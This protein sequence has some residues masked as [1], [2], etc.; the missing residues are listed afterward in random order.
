MP[1]LMIIQASVS[2][3]DKYKAYQEG[4]KP[5]IESFGGHFKASG[6][7]LEVLEGGHDGRRLIVF[8]FPSVEDIRR[9]WESPAYAAVK[10]LRDGAA[11]IDVWAVPGV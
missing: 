8:E 6:V 9:F 4:V 2:Q 7:G 5:V 10:P 11:K 1:A 3:K